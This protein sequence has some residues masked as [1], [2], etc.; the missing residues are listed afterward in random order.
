MTLI[1]GVTTGTKIQLLSDTR[2]THPDVTQIEEI[3]GRLKLISL[4]ST[5]CVGYAGPATAAI[6]HIRTTP[7]DIRGSF[8]HLIPYLQAESQCDFLLAD[9]R[10]LRLATVKGGVALET[11]PAYV[12]DDDAWAAFLAARDG[13]VQADS[14]DPESATLSSAMTA[15]ASVM[16]DRS[17]PTVAGF[18]LRVGSRGD[19]FHYLLAAGAYLVNLIGPLNPSTA[20][21]HSDAAAGAYSYTVLAPREAGHP[22]VAVHLYQGQLGFVYAPLKHD[23][24]VEVPNVDHMGL[25]QYVR[26][27]YGI[28]VDGLQIGAGTFSVPKGY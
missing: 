3:P 9:S 5:I 28:E 19:G 2:I 20:P 1:V 15:F 12:G 18:Q 8:E 21:Q 4:S 16:R 14:T 24:P 22:V 13:V 7:S 10:S 17:H 26:Q 11:A 25:Q 6:D 23:T 27:H